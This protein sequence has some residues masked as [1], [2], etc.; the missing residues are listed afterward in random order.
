M[1]TLIFFG[2]LALYMTYHIGSSVMSGK[3]EF[4][5]VMKVEFEWSKEP[6]GFLVMLAINSALLLLSV[7]F[8]YVKYSQLWG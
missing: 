3:F 4:D 2:L 7:Y 5:Y 8:V 6:F 1:I